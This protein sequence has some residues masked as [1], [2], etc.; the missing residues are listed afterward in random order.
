MVNT[1]LLQSPQ[2][3]LLPHTILTITNFSTTVLKRFIVNYFDVADK[4]TVNI[5][6][7]LD[8]PDYLTYTKS[9]N[10]L[11]LLLLLF[12]SVYYFHNKVPS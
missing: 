11:L 5:K 6:N 1:G 3:N 2:E 4:V 7:L 9:E 10:A 12:L 8:Q